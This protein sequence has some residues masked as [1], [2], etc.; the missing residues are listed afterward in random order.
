MSSTGDQEP[1]D[2]GVLSS[3]IGSRGDRFSAAQE[4]MESRLHLGNEDGTAG[5][6][7]LLLQKLRQKTR[8][9]IA[10]NRIASKHFSSR[11]FIWFFLPQVLLGL[12]ASIISFLADSTGTLAIIQ[13]KFFRDK[14]ILT[15]DL[16]NSTTFDFDND[17]VN[18]ELETIKLKAGMTTLVGIISLI[19]VAFQT[20]SREKQFGERGVMHNIAAESFHHLEIELDSLISIY[21][22]GDEDEKVEDVKRILLR[23]QRRF[24]EIEVSCKSP[25][26]IELENAFILLES[27]IECSAFKDVKQ[28]YT[29]DSDEFH[30]FATQ[31]LSQEICAARFYPQ[32]LPRADI[33]VQNATARVNSRFHEMSVQDLK[34]KKKM[35]Q[36]EEE[37]EDRAQWQR[38]RQM[39]RELKKADFDSVRD[40]PK[41]MKEKL[42]KAMINR[43]QKK[44]KKIMK[45]LTQPW[46]KDETIVFDTES[47]RFRDIS[48]VSDGM[49]QNI[50]EEREEV[51]D[52]ELGN[53]EKDDEKIKSESV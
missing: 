48:L 30:K 37:R 39:I 51:E 49:C 42:R 29:Q 11:Q 41:E 27:N 47:E 40:K 9:S 2:R 16:S 45:G 28:K 44:K 32:M 19:I 26:P 50:S 8:N 7:L 5:D 22:M 23:L 53:E 18:D 52:E 21:S 34:L 38:E 35:W 17:D 31:I 46:Y 6:A 33:M 14:L 43:E 1:Y 20:V 15:N 36:L 10:Q 12:I 4:L 25:L 13:E 24:R 3:S